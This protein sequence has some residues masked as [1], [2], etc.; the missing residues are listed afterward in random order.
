MYL[1][2][3][4]T[5]EDARYHTKMMGFDIFGQEKRGESEGFRKGAGDL[6]F[7]V[8]MIEIKAQLT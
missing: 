3:I 2:R 4:P 6:E 1:H 8:P 7:L 5:E